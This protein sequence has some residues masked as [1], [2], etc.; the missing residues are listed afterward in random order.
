MA[1]TRTRTTILVLVVLGCRSRVG[2]PTGEPSAE[3][4]P[5]AAAAPRPAPRGRTVYDFSANRVSAHVFRDGELLIDCG[6]PAFMKYALGGWRSGWATG[7]HD[8]GRSVAFTLG[9]AASVQVPVDGD[10]GGPGVGD[11]RL[12]ATL[13]PVPARQRVS[14]FVN[15][16]PAG[17]VDLVPG[18]QD[19]DLPVT[20]R[21]GENSVRFYFRA[22][23]DSPAGRSA[24]AFEKISIAP[25]SPKP[26]WRASF[27]VQV[28]TGV[29]LWTAPGFRVQA[30]R[31]REAARPLGD[32]GTLAGEAARLDFLS[33][34]THPLQAHLVAPGPAAVAPPR[35]PARRIFVWMI[36]TLRP[37]H[38]GCYNPKTPVRTPSLD[39]FAKKGVRFEHATAQGNWSLPSHASLLSG[40]YPSVHGAYTEQ[41][42]VPDSIE[43]A[44][45]I[46]GKQGFT[47]ATF[48]SNGY[49]SD[50]W[51]FA[52]GWDHYR[53]FVRESRPS[54]AKALW[55]EALAW[56]R[57]R[58]LDERLFVYLGTID[59]HVIYNPPADYLAMYDAGPYT[60]M[61]KPAM[62]AI[63]LGR[64]K[65]GKATLSD[66]DKR[67]LESL[68]DGEITYNDYWFGRMQEDLGALHMLD[69]AVIV[70]VSDHGDEFYDHGSVGHGHTVYQELVASPLLLAGCGLPAGR[71]VEADVETLDV[72][73]TLLDL[74]GLPAAPTVQGESLLPLVDEPGP[75]AARPAF[76]THGG[77]LRGMKIGRY[78][79]VTSGPEQTRLFD[80]FTD[81]GEQR[82]V[83][84]EQPL[85]LRHARDVFSLHVG[86][87]TRWKK[88][89]WGVASNL[90]P[91]FATDV[92]F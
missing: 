58:K 78:K 35:P 82:D 57:Q 32:V 67:R 53:N 5:A 54:D 59:P 41:T 76:S 64:I 77:V 13:R 39:A 25:R 27:Y 56:I 15:D 47:T 12:R 52:Q 6:T 18:W 2:S 48:L 29:T 50:R 51:G 72:L 71:E 61:V 24:A 37:D 11:V 46:F 74:A 80:L 17:N 10:A 88:S 20:L 31:G 8:D 30:A 79:M 49:V 81:P 1:V 90:R 23:G 19:L 9:V 70:V 68:Y 73:P 43:L 14:V 62:T 3:A 21:A 38:V 55:T 4:A 83:S 66:R 84:Y 85:A 33:D 65:T 42:R 26:G 45:E 60:G 87:E 86:Y 16:K 28:P 22:A 75:Q 91:E 92:G 40:V 63:L 7:R 36:D 44:G 69:D 34:G 89:R